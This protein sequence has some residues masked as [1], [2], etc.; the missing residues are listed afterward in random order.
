[1][2]FWNEHCPKPLDLHARL[3][4]ATRA[5]TGTAD[6][7]NDLINALAAYEA[8][9]DHNHGSGPIAPGAPCPGGDCTVHVA[10]GLLAG[11]ITRDA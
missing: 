10:R 2:L 3:L 5:F 11:R 1:M 7:R 6:T 4:Q 9:G 8:T